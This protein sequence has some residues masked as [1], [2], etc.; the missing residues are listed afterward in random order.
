MSRKAKT[1]LIV[2]TILLALFAP[3]TLM[4]LIDRGFDFAFL[5]FNQ[6]AETLSNLPTTVPSP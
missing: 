1:T 6:G 2:I 5:L 4:M 3:A